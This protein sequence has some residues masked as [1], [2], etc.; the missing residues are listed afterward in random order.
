MGVQNIIRKERLEFLKVIILYGIELGLVFFFE[1]LVSNTNNY[2]GLGDFRYIYYLYAFITFIPF[3]AYFLNKKQ[4][5]FSPI[6]LVDGKRSL[7]LYFIAEWF[8][9]IFPAILFSILLVSFHADYYIGSTVLAGVLLVYT[10]IA[11]IIWFL[12]YFVSKKDTKVIALAVVGFILAVLF[13]QSNN[14]QAEFALLVV[15]EGILIPLIPTFFSSLSQLLADLFKKNLA[16]YILEIE[17]LFVASLIALLLAALVSNSMIPNTYFKLLA[18]T[19]IELVYIFLMSVGLALL[20][21]ALVGFLRIIYKLIRY[22]RTDSLNI[23]RDNMQKAISNLPLQIGEHCIEAESLKPLL[24]GSV[25]WWDKQALDS[26]IKAGLKLEL[27]PEDSK[28]I[29]DNIIKKFVD[30]LSEL[31]PELI[32]EYILL[33]EELNKKAN[34]NKRIIVAILDVIRGYNLYYWPNIDR[35]MKKDTK[36][37]ETFDLIMRSIEKKQIGVDKYKQLLAKYNTILS[38]IKQIDETI[39]KL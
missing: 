39:E 10:L 37:R 25:H 27:L 11:A 1:V 2:L 24:T 28:I 3:I 15:V 23:V 14:L 29:V 4:E 32:K 7:N 30:N 38:Y 22:L 18:L 12:V 36:M 8:L 31:A 21:L 26:N 16:E 9:P 13:I 35:E 5:M 19:K 33:Y 17:S 6:K 34:G 20:F